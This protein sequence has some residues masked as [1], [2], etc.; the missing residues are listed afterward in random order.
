MKRLLLLLLFFATLFIKSAK[1]QDV[2]IPDPNFWKIALYVSDKNNDQKI[3][4]SE[5]EKVTFLE[6]RGNNISDLTGIEAFVN[7]DTLLVATNNLT[8]LDVSKNR[9]LKFLNCAI[10]KLSALDIS[11]NLELGTLV[12]NENY[13]TSLDLSMADSLVELWCFK[14]NLDELDLSSCRKLKNLF[15]ASNSIE[16]IDLSDNS[17]LVAFDCS[18][19]GLTHLDLSNNLSLIVLGCSSNGLSHLDVSRNIDLQYVKCDENQFEYLDFSHNENIDSLFCRNMPSL[20]SI[21]VPDVD[22]ANTYYH[23]DITAEWIDDCVLG[24]NHD[25]KEPAI[26]IFPNP[27]KN[28]VHLEENSSWEVFDVHD[29]LIMSGFSHQVDLANQSSGVYIIRITGKNGLT[30]SQRLIKE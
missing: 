1:A 18:L 5:A 13:L 17:Q 25:Q 21:C 9:K 28:T 29:K 19:N 6:L 7:L 4:V 24:I 15:M 11:S 23:K 2:Y 16:T 14:N 22:F 30:Y 8:V 3:Q 27:T 10:N 20:K 12:C 26:N